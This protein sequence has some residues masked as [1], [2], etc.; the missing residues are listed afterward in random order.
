MN[1]CPGSP[2]PFQELWVLQCREE[3]LRAIPGAE[4]NYP[5]IGHE[6]LGHGVN[7]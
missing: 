6:V 5:G 1:A 2:S 4:L 7:Q 3:F